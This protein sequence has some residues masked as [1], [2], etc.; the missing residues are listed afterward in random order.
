[1]TSGDARHRPSRARIGLEPSEATV[2]AEQFGVAMDQVERDHAI[3]HV[4]GAIAGIERSND[5]VFFGGTALAR[6]HLPDLRLSED[7]DLIARGNRE[8]ISREIADTVEMRLARQFTSI[9]WAP[10]IRRTKGFEAAVL[11]LNGRIRIQVQL[12]GESG[13][14]RWPTERRTITQR[15]SDAPE[16]TL[17]VLTRP[18]FVAAKTAAWMDRR[19]PR[20][21]TTCGRWHG[22][23][24]SARPLPSS[25]AVMARR[26][27]CPRLAPSPTHRRSTSGTPR[28]RSSAVLSSDR[29]RRRKSSRRP[30]RLSPDA[31]LPSG[32]DRAP[33][34][35]IEQLSPHAR[36]P[37]LTHR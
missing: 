9:R 26:R 19:A 34:S 31:R 22:R 2:V 7:I 3:S 21:C 5:L 4:L 16:A 23:D 6:T 30:G 11:E 20:D 12:L 24:S 1:M 8:A 17:Q 33:G 15:Y 29:R 37:G 18:A 27:L 28:S 13:Y 14:P 10:D 35:T 25:C 36:R 32:Q